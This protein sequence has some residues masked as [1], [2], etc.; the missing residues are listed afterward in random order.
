MWMRWLLA[1]VCSWPQDPAD[2]GR[3]LRVLSDLGHRGH[4]LKVPRADCTRRTGAEYGEA[5]VAAV[6]GEG[7][8]QAR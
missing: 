6:P 5:A 4:D 7:H 2:S 8:A 1:A 3:S